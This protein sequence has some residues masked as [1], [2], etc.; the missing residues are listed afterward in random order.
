MSER[1]MVRLLLARFPGD[2]E[3]HVV[4]G[5]DRTVWDHWDNDDEARWKTDAQRLWGCDP[6]DCEW[7]EVW[8][9]FAPQALVDAF[10]T[11]EVD[12]DVVG[13]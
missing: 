3:P 9:V 4:A 5:V 2:T 1:V 13:A 7:R 8:A 11:P 6:T 12:A 10:A